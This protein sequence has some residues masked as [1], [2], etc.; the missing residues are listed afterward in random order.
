MPS[1]QQSKNKGGRPKKLHKKQGSDQQLKSKY[2]HLVVPRLQ[3]YASASPEQ[4]QQLKYSTQALLQQRQ[5]AKG[6]RYHTVALQTHEDGHYHL[7]ILLVYDKSVR[8]SLTHFDYLPKHP[9]ITVY[10][11]LNAAIL[12]YG[13]KQDTQA[14]SNLPDD[15]S[16]IIRVDK[17]KADPYRYLQL[18]MLK[19]PLHFNLQQYVRKNDL[20]QYLTTWSSIKSRLKDSQVAAANLKLRSKSGF[21]FINR[22]LLEANLNSQQLKAYDSWSGYQTIVDYLNQIPVYGYKRPLKTMNLLITGQ[23]NTGKTSLFSNRYP[24]PDQNPVSGYTSVYPMGA[25]T[26]WPNYRPQVYG[27]IFW[28]QAK[29]TSYSYDTIL[30]VLQGSQVDLPYKGGSVLKYDNPLVV[31]TSNMTLQ[32]MIQQKFGYSEELRKMARSNLAVR[33]QNVVVPQGYNLFLLQKLLLAA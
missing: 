31:M 32:Q 18:Q 22:A 19:D 14:L 29:L 25:K 8:H 24:K 33:V 28:N 30:K 12:A 1:F 20:N 4:L 21:K 2:W 11:K 5:S 3:D 9:H 23:P 26:W 17:L 10:R 13:K 16:Q 7:D 6:L 27:M 15:M